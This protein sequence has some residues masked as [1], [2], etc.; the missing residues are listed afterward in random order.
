M[1]SIVDFCTT[2]KSPSNYY[3]RNDFTFKRQLR[4]AL[5]LKFTLK[6]CLSMKILSIGIKELLNKEQTGFNG[7]DFLEN[8]QLTGFKE[9]FNDYHAKPFIP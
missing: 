3:P 9:L 4:R 8:N 6:P 2:D 1:S 5:Q 7:N